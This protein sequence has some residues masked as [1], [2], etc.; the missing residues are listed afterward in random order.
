MKLFVNRLIIWIKKNKFKLTF[1][2]PLALFVN[3]FPLV[4]LDIPN[5]NPYNNYNNSILTKLLLINGN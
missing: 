5:C 4:F 3:K 1:L 2:L